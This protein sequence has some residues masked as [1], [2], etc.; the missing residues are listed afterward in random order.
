MPGPRT[1]FPGLM[2][3]VLGDYHISD[4]NFTAAFDVD[5]DKVG[6]DLSEA[7]FS[8]SEQHLQVH[9]RARP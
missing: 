1:R 5:A 7:I 9:R 2:H 8:G 6:K 4:I 3:P